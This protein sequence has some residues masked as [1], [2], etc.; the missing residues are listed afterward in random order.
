MICSLWEV[1]NQHITL[2][3]IYREMEGKKGT[4]NAKQ[5]QRIRESAEKMAKVIIE[6]DNQQEALAYHYPHV[7]AGRT[8]LLPSESVTNRSVEMNGKILDYCLFLYREPP[9]LTYAKAHKQ[10]TMFTPE[11]ASLPDGLSTTEDNLQLDDY[12][13]F[14][15]A[16]LETYGTKILFKTIYE[17]C[18]IDDKH[19]R[20]RAM[21]KI[22][23]LLAHYQ[24][25]KLIKSF[26]EQPDGITFTI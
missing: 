4:P 5:A 14:R 18:G 9:L 3:Q 13:K 25:T 24:K 2:S 19:K 12:L 17:N 11:Q 22:R 1:G 21:S 16:R 6:I 26:R 20:S 8:Y 10:F 15:I 23:K 7:Q